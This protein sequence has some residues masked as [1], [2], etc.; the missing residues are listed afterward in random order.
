MPT[1]TPSPRPVHRPAAARRVPPRARGLTLI[2]LMLVIALLGL[3][4]ALV[5][6]SMREMIDVRRLRAV[7]AQLVTDLQ[8]ARSEA[9]AQRVIVRAILHTDPVS[10]PGSTCYTLY[11][12]PSYHDAQRCDCRLGEGNA[13]PAGSRELKTVVLPRQRGVELFI[14]GGLQSEV[15][16]SFGF[17]PTM[18]SLVAI[19][20][21]RWSDELADFRI[22]TRLNPEQVLRV[23]LSQTGRP[24]GCAPAGSRVTDTPCP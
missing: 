4:L 14:P 1:Q 6:P 10:Q 9:V 16:N 15:E 18:G 19:P 13:C 17:E 3:L 23:V 8:W 11:V 5:A 7:H 24:G 12:A 22:D 20:I 2:E 21:D